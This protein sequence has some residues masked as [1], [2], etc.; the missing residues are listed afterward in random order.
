MRRRERTLVGE[1]TLR[2]TAGEKGH[3]PSLV[4]AGAALWEEPVKLWG[5][6]FFSRQQEP[7][8]QLKPRA[9]SQ[10]FSAQGLGHPRSSFI[11]CFH[12]DY[13]EGFLLLCTPREF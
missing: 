12:T 1:A 9:R 5:R 11:C 6:T 4:S 2:R 3:A 10:L 8:T 13:G 7:P